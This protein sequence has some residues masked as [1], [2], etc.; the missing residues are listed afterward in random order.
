MMSIKPLT[1]NDYLFAQD[2]RRQVDKI[3]VDCIKLAAILYN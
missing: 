2:L 1:Q 3:N